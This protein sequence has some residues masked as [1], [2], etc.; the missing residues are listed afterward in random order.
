QRAMS[1]RTGRHQRVAACGGGYLEPVSQPSVRG[2]RGRGG[3][4]RRGGSG[5]HGSA[6]D[7]ALSTRRGDGIRAGAAAG[8]GRDSGT[9]GRVP[10]GEPAVAPVLRVWGG[11]PGRDGGGRDEA[12]E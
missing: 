4:G 6:A 8:P 3:R 7:R 10:A 12:G 11:R 1:R 5:G 2:R 9:A